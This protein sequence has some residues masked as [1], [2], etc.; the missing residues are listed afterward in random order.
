MKG[1]EEMDAGA[2]YHAECD[3]H[4]P[5]I[6]YRRYVYD[7]QRY[8]C[9]TAPGTPLQIGKRRSGRNERSGHC[10]TAWRI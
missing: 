10:L 9:K 2:S 5:I 1:G 8:F 3:D 7:E 4:I 6:A